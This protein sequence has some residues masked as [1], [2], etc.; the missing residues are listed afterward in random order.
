[1]KKRNRPDAPRVRNVFLHGKPRNGQIDLFHYIYLYVY[2]FS[3]LF[4][5]L[6]VY[7]SIC[8]SVCLFF[9]LFVCLPIY[10]FI[11]SVCGRRYISTYSPFPVYNRLSRVTPTC[12]TEVLGKL[13]V[14]KGVFKCFCIIISSRHGNKYC[15]PNSKY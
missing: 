1:M 10:L 3:F 9:N 13:Y 11:Y 4:A 7:P 14:V 6:S 5:H 8:L 2:Q 12:P 15:A